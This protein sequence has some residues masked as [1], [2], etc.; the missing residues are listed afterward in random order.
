MGVMKKIESAAAE[1]KLFESTVENI[2]IWANAEFLPEWVDASINELV[3]QEAWDELNDRF[4]KNLDFGTAGMRGRTIGRVSSSVE[5]GNL[6]AQNGSPLRAAVGTNVLNDFNV[7]RATIGLFRYV[8]QYLNKTGHYDLPRFVIAHDVR[9]F[10]RHFCE[11]S[12]STWNQLGGR[13]IIFIGPR[14]TPQL[15]YSVRHYKAHCGAVITASHNPSNHNGFKVYFGDGAQ[16]VSPHA[17]SIVNWVN[18]VTL[19]EV[20]AYLE[21]NLKGVITL[22]NEADASYCQLLG[23]T[24]LD[25]DV[26][27]KHKVRAVFT[28]VHGTGATSSVPVLKKLGVEVIEVSE[29]MVQDGRFPTVK[30][31]NPENTETLEMAIAKANE[32]GGRCGDC[33]GP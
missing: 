6:Q 14:S 23:E 15:S 4:Y 25:H 28:P 8:S 22:G 16:V 7:I 30:S 32:T 1:G 18:Q 17:E 10:S 5:E 19:K 11:L 2:K 33:H 13:A 3:T 29:Q 12:A 24:V 27:Q 26:M 9:H 20:S 21:I 31:P